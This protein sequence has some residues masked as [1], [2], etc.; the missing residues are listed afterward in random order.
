MNTVTMAI[1]K[2]QW[3]STINMI[4]GQ[5]NCYSNC[6][7]DYKPDIPHDLNGFFE[8]L[9]DKCNHALWNH[10]RCHAEW[11]QVMNTQASIDQNMKGWE[12]AKDGNEKTAILVG[13]RENLVHDLDQT[14]AW[15]TN[16][17]AQQ[18]GRYSYLPL[19]G[20]FSTQVGSAIR[21]LEQNYIALEKKGA[22][23]D[24]LQR[25]KESLSNM[26]RKLELFGIAKE[27]EG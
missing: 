18:V 22:D 4:C 17:L 25:V 11:G 13:V 21:L 9:C 27:N 8:G 6:Y 2:Q 12:A 24:H 5:A 26:K 3:S 10:H 19:S 7:I 20:G 15:A 14:I 23:H 16:D 1:W